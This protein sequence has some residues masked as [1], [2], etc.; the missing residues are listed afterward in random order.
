MFLYKVC[1]ALQSAGIPYAVVGGYAVAL[2]GVIRGTF[3]VDIVIKWTLENLKKL[4]TTLSELGLVSRIPVNAENVFYFRDEYVKNRNLIA[5][6]FY[7]KVNPANQVDII[8]T[9]DLTKRHTTNIKTIYGN[10]KVLSIKDLIEMKKQAGRA[11]DLEDIKALE[12][13]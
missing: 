6:N 13:L 2:H 12:G 4:E 1:S 7:D 8:I 5:W 9:Y 3:D 11:Q 10:I